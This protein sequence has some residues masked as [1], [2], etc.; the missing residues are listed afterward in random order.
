M[1]AVNFMG[2]ENLCVSGQ[3][4]AIV[5]NPIHELFVPESICGIVIRPHMFNIEMFDNVYQPVQVVTVGV[6]KHH[7]IDGFNLFL[8]QEGGDNPGAYIKDTIIG[9]TAAVQ[10]NRVSIGE[11]QKD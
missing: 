8:P 3:M 9:K 4:N 2:S 7:C 10:K 1:N 6:R 5:S 11:F